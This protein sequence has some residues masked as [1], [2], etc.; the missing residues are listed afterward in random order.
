[1]PETTDEI[2]IT[3][4][5]RRKIEGRVLLP[6]IEA[7]GEKFGDGVT[8]EL[9]ISTIRRLATEYG[10]RWASAHGRGLASLKTVVEQIWAGGGSL[11]VE[12]VSAHD[13]HLHFNVTRCRY[14]EFYKSLGVADLGYLLHRNRDYA[15]IDRFDFDIKL[16]RTQTVMEGA[17]HCDFR[18]K[19]KEQSSSGERHP[20]LRFVSRT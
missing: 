9:I 10:A 19:A 6:L 7:C 20:A 17:S 16:T 4:L 12:I 1:M 8:R 14:A 11:D 18:F 3:H 13:D 5:Q 2:P 15:M